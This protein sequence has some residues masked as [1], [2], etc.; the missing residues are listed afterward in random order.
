MSH[1]GKKLK[2]P[3]SPWK[4]PW[5]FRES[6]I[7]SIILLLIGFIIEILIDGKNISM[8]SWPYNLFTII[9][10]I[11]L[12]VLCQNFLD[13]PII[14]WFSSIP[15]AISSI[16]VFTLLTL[17]LGFIAQNEP[18]TS[19]IIN[20]LGLTHIIQSWPYVI[21]SFFF[22]T[23]LGFTIVK[24]IKIS[25]LKNFATFLNHAGLWI[26]IAA[27]SMG[28]S[29]IIHTKMIVYENQ[30]SNIVYDDKNNSYEMPFAIE[31]LDFRIDEYTPHLILIDKSNQ[32]IKNNNGEHRFAIKEGASYKIQDWQI[33]IKKYLASSNPAVNEYLH[34]DTKGGAPAALVEISNSSLSDNSYVTEGW[35][36]RGSI[37]FNNK[38]IQIND[39]HLLFMEKPQISKFV[40]DVKV[41]LNDG[42]SQE[43]QIEVNSPLNINGW[44]IYQTGYNDKLGKLSNYSVFSLVKDPW[45]KVIYL[46]I[47]MLLGGATLI[48]WYGKLS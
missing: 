13:H 3:R 14:R 40:S 5:K 46:G 17:L 27:A 1:P 42:S 37:I 33:T 7:I 41:Y 44:E 23:V 20:N 10:F 2:K 19:P 32:V 12:I 16:S 24:R 43:A 15:A 36:S 38:G 21:L 18:H 6:F 28:T 22:L 4:P 11:V 30:I 47:Y 34:T 29:D 26:I 31:L 48:L 8:P 25:S 35:I 39:N 45:L 9:S